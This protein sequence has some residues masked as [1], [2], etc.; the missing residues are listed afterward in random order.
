M[1]ETTVRLIEQFQ[2]GDADSADELFQRYV[3]RLSRLVRPRLSARLARRVDPE[4]I[5]MSAYRSFFLGARDG[6]FLIRRSGDL[7]ALLVRMTLHKLYRTAAHHR[8]EK[9]SI[10]AEAPAAADIDQV[11]S[12]EPTPDEAAALADT[13]ESLLAGLTVPH[14]RMLELRLQGERI[15]DIAIETNVTERTVRRVLGQVRVQLGSTEP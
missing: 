7:W 5:V 12:D 13:L 10:D 14:R 9:R 4:D 6:R 8:A 2:S 15:A 1:A 11:R 3:E